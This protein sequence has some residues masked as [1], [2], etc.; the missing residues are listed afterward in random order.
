MKT[1]DW[2]AVYGA[3][4]S[5]FTLLWTVAKARSR[6][7]VVMLYG[8]EGDKQGAYISVQNR[9]GHAVRISAISLAYQLETTAWVRLV[10]LVKYRR[11][12]QWAGWVRVPLRTRGVKDGCPVT[13]PP[14]D[15]YH[16]IVEHQLVD[17]LINES[18]SDSVVAIIQDVL[19]NDVYSN[20]YQGF[21]RAHPD[22]KR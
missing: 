15:E 20:K 13:I 8:Y 4:I 16:I 10:Q 18:A 21:R 19:W 3:A 22:E 17:D 11:I 2:L 1:T 6:I 7:K 5:T 12:T 14:H 9:S